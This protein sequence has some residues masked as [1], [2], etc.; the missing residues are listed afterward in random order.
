M[1]GLKV[2]MGKLARFLSENIPRAIGV[3][4]SISAVAIFVLMVL[5]VA[6]ATMR[7]SF[8]K[9]IPVAWQLEITLIVLI[10]VFGFART[11][12]MKQHINVTVLSKFMNKRQHMILDA[13][14]CGLGFIVFTLVV[15]QAWLW[16]AD[17]W[18]VNEYFHGIVKL[19]VYPTKFAFM[20][21][22]A[23]FNIQYLLDF[24]HLIRSLTK[25]KEETL[26]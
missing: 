21:G 16:T 13:F 15:W 6:D 23:A 19:P 22:A 24:L 4:Y 8:T 11:Q 12:A 20:L 10:G 1:V 17:S 3:L 14:G 25:E 2:V 5:M 7:K 26:R 18:R 9:V